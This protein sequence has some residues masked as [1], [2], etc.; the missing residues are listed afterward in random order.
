MVK[1]EKN[2]RNMK[3]RKMK[4]TKVKTKKTKKTKKKISVLI[5]AHCTANGTGEAR[6]L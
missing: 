6:N 1:E 2:G 4:R 5:R 3:K